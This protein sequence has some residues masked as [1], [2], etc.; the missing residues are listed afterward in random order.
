[1]S[2]NRPRPQLQDRGRNEDPRLTFSTPEF[3][4]AQRV[5]TDNFKVLTGGQAQGEGRI[6]PA[7]YHRFYL[8]CTQHAAAFIGTTVPCTDSSSYFS[9][10]CLMCTEELWSPCGVGHGQGVPLVHPAAEAA[11]EPS[12]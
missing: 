10:T 11:G 5:F 1:M 7:V 3:K 8:A 12:E 9:A 4:E 6:Q 2:L